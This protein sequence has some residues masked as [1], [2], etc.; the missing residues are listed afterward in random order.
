MKQTSNQSC[1][2]WSADQRSMAFTFISRHNS[3]HAS[4]YNLHDS[5]VLFNGPSRSLLQVQPLMFVIET[6]FSIKS[7]SKNVKTFGALH[8]LNL[9]CASILIQILLVQ[10]ERCHYQAYSKSLKT[11]YKY[12]WP[13]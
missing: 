6:I 10:S 13:G 11:I 5:F 2:C 4:E 3:K 8:P 1:L 12:L 9:S 7:G